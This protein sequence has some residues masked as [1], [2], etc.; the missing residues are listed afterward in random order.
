[1]RARKHPATE[2]Q[3]LRELVFSRGVERSLGARRCEC[4]FIRRLSVPSPG[5]KASVWGKLSQAGCCAPR[6]PGGGSIFGHYC[7]IRA[8]PLPSA[9]EVRDEGLLVIG[10]PGV[11]ECKEVSDW[12]G[13]D[14]A[15]VD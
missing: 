15:G 12:T 1:M 7:Q 4:H 10:P 14:S 13:V 11:V 8:Y 6:P 5:A 2:K 3:S 9:G